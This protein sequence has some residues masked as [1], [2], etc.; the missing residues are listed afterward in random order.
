VWI[1]CTATQNWITAR[2]KM[3]GAS[4]C[5]D[6]KTARRGMLVTK[7]ISYP[8]IRVDVCLR[9]L[10]ELY[11]CCAALRLLHLLR[12]MQAELTPWKHHVQH[13]NHA[14]LSRLHCRGRELSRVWKQ[15][16][17][18]S[19]GLLHPEMCRKHFAEPRRPRRLRLQAGAWQ[20]HSAN[21]CFHC[22]P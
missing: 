11:A 12:A 8:S 7:Y 15:F 2:S 16:L 22:E 6:Y 17:C 5:C 18:C 21:C 1:K 10:L 13:A 9:L 4:L 3:A 14:L 19:R 20:D